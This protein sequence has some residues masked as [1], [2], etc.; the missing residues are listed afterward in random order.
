MVEV[1]VVRRKDIAAEF[2]R[3]F[4]AADLPAVRWR[5]QNLNGLNPQK[6]EALVRQLGKVLAG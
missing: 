3:S 6:R 5:R 4:A 2:E 1:L